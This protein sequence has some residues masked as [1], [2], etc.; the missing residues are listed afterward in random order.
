MPGAR[1]GFSSLPEQIYRR[2]LRKG[3]QL[4]ILVV[5]EAG[6]GKST[7]INSMFLTDIYTSSGI[8]RTE[9]TTDI[10]EHQVIEM[11]FGLT[12]MKKN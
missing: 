2:S 4:C 3:F 8:A 12:A 7:L 11:A 10:R 9:K 1:V 6:L 5:G